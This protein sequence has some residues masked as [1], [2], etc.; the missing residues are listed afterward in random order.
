MAVPSSSSR[1]SHGPSLKKSK[2]SRWVVVVNSRLPPASSTMDSSDGAP[3]FSSGWE[4]RGSDSQMQMATSAQAS[5]GTMKMA[6][7]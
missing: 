3:E 4:R 1:A 2:A 5:A 6:R 7:H